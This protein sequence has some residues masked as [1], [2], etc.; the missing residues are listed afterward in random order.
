MHEDTITKCSVHVIHTGLSVEA[1]KVYLTQTFLCWLLP[2]APPQ[3]L[4]GPGTCSSCVLNEGSI[5]QRF[6]GCQ[7]HHC[8]HLTPLQTRAQGTVGKSDFKW[9][10]VWTQG[11]L[12]ARQPLYHLKPPTPLPVLSTLFFRWGLSLCFCLGLAS[13]FEP[14]TYAFFPPA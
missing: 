10:R 1:A 9:G 7:G 12:L 8:V 6:T 13:D 2:C 4:R 5:D 11:F 3:A 14:P